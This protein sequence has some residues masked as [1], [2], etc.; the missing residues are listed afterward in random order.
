MTIMRDNIMELPEMQGNE[1][2]LDAWD[3]AFFRV[4]PSQYAI[5]F[6]KAVLMD[7]P[8]AF[9]DWSVFYEYRIGK[10]KDWAFANSGKIDIYM[11]ILATDKMRSV[12][13]G[14]P[15]SALDFIE[16]K[17]DDLTTPQAQLDMI[18]MADVLYSGTLVNLSQWRADR[19]R[20]ER[21]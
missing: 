21:E 14:I 18:R 7:P 4:S 16:I 11:T 17:H 6:T 5:P 19:H 15:L 12:K 13:I 2:V 10:Q 1:R 20:E 9:D 3:L 8:S